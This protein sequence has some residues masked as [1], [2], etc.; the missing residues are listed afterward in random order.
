MELNTSSFQTRDIIN[1]VVD[2]IQEGLVMLHLVGKQVDMVKNIANAN[3][4]NNY[5]ISQSNLVV[6]II[7]AIL[8]KLLTEIVCVFFL[9]YLTRA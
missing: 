3:K 9:M 8:H 6:T 7:T 4:Y 1:H 2:F 5:E